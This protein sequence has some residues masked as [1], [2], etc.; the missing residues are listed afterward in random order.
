[1]SESATDPNS[2]LLL[3]KSVAL[4]CRSIWPIDQDDL[5]LGHGDSL[6]IAIV[7]TLESFHQSVWTDIYD[8]EALAMDSLCAAVGGD[9]NEWLDD[10]GIDV[11]V[12]KTQRILTGIFDGTDFASMCSPGDKENRWCS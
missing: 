2:V 7:S 10:F 12:S 3:A 6:Q 1:M 4:K 11:C 8:G 9:I 5:N